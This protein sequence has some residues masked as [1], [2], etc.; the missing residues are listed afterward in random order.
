MEGNGRGDAVRRDRIAATGK[1]ISARGAG[2]MVRG[3]GQMPPERE[4]LYDQIRG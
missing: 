4:E 1:S 3:K 2:Q